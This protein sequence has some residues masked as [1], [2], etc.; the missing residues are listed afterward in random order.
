MEQKQIK[1][2]I[3]DGYLY[4]RVI[5]EIV[6]TPKEHVEESLKE[7][8]KKI[9]ADKTYT[10]IKEKSEKAEKQENGLFSAF[11]EMEMLMKDT[12]LLLNFCFDYLPSSIE[13]IE[14]EKLIIKNSDFGD[15]MNDLL[16]R[17]IT[18]NTTVIQTTERNQFYVKNTAVLL[19]NFIVVLLSSKPMT[20]KQISPYLGV[21]EEDVKK[22][23]DVLI[24]EKKVKKDGEVYKVI[25]KD[26]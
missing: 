9:K 22:V 4:L 8:V 20:I 19:R 1:S 11:S 13:V 7:Y 10:I 14:P 2:K 23:I 12:S 5:L 6:G 24:N 25:P 16:A 3:A 26:G 15:F 17:T 18:L 21:K